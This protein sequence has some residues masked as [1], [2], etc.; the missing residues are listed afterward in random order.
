MLIKLRRVMVHYTQLCAGSQGDGSNTTTSA[1]RCQAGPSVSY[2]CGLA[3]LFLKHPNMDRAQPPL[4]AG[5][6]ISSQ[7]RHTSEQRIQWSPKQALC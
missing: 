2:R 6:N 5:A 7:M 4:P 3:G 1:P